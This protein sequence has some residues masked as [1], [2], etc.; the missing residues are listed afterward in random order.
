MNEKGGSTFAQDTLA[1][2]FDA[3]CDGG[4]NNFEIRVHEDFTEADAASAAEKYGK[5]VGRL[6]KVLRA[7]IGKAT[8]IRKLSLGALADAAAADRTVTVSI[9]SSSTGSAPKLTA[10]GL[11]GGAAGARTGD[12]QITLDDS[13]SQAVATVDPALVAEVR[14]LAEQTQHGQAHVDRAGGACWW[15]SGWS[16]MRAFRRRR[17]RRPRRPGSGSVWREADAWR[18]T[19]AVSCR[20]SKSARATTAAMRRPASGWRSAAGSRGATRCWGLI[21]DVSGCTLIAHGNDDLKDRG[22]AAA[23]VYRPDPATQRGPS[24]N[25]R[26]EFGGQARGGLDALFQPDPLEDRT[27]GE[28]TSRWAME[29]AY[30]F[31]AFG[32]RWTGRASTG[33]PVRAKSALVIAGASGGRPGSPT[34]VGGSFDGTICMSTGGM[35]GI[36]GMTKMML[37]SDAKK[38][39]EEIVKAM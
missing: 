17:R 2:L 28:A 5:A 37:F 8:G 36:L 15:R 12:G 24:L 27:G 35:S 34:P 31:P 22:Y 19:A 30:G 3:R 4:A 7:G 9:P 32:G 20:S 11:G 29:A 6:P 39:V 21:L 10:T 38:M 18:W 14:A 25:L 1:W 33:S 13:T 26:Q 23:L 16:R